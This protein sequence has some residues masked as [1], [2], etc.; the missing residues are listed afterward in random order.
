MTA[1][2]LDALPSWDKELETRFFATKRKTIEDMVKREQEKLD[3]T[4]R[5][6][7]DNYLD[8]PDWK[9]K[10]EAVIARANGICEGCG[11]GKATEAH[12]LTYDDF[13][14]EFLFQLVALCENC[15]VRWH[16][17]RAAEARDPNTPDSPF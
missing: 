15:H 4:R 12:H 11:K 1:A 7:Y 6:R 14:D 8:G 17:R 16:A 3:A 2:Q 9:E 10:R 5:R 13:G